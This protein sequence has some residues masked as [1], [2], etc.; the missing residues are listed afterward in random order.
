MEGGPVTRAVGSC[1]LKEKLGF[2]EAEKL[3]RQFEACGATVE[4]KL[5]VLPSLLLIFYAQLP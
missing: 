1:A 4:I 2:A 3:K 5:L